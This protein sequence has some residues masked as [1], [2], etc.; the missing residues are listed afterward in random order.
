[1]RRNKGIRARHEDFCFTTG[2]AAFVK[3]LNPEASMSSGFKAAVWIAR[4]YYEVRY[5]KFYS[6]GNVLFFN[7]S[8]II[9]ALLALVASGIFCTS[10]RRSNAETSGS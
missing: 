5:R 7:D 6:I 4:G 2:I 3:K 10:Q 9:V 8:S 1:M